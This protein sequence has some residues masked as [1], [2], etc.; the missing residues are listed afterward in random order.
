MS[1]P[2]VTW[3]VF[4]SPPSFRVEVTLVQRGCDDVFDLDLKK[5]R[6]EKEKRKKLCEKKN[7]FLVFRI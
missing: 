7:R 1:A 5:K 4:G 6:K 2:F 3:S